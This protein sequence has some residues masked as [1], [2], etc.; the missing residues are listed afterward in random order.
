MTSTDQDLYEIRIEGELDPSW[1][2][3]FDDLQVTNTVEGHAIL[4]GPLP[5]QAALY[6]VLI[7]VQNLGLTLLSVNR[8]VGGEVRAA[9]EVPGLRRGAK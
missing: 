7:K 6:A 5:D 8:A 9:A 4:H 3:W 1:S 2:E